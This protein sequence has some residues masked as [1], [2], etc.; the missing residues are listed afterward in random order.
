MRRAVVIQPLARIVVAEFE[1]HFV[2]VG[3]HSKLVAQL[4][5]QRGACPSAPSPKARGHDQPGPVVLRQPVLVPFSDCDSVS[6]L[7]LDE[8]PPSLACAKLAEQKTTTTE[9]CQAMRLH[10]EDRNM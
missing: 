10:R 6:A 3:R 2:Y 9:T 8:L 4:V 7:S 5:G 1:T